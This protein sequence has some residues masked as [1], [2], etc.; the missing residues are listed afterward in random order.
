MKLQE[1]GARET[2]KQQ[3]SIDIK[4]VSIILSQSLIAGVIILLAI[5]IVQ[6]MEI[7]LYFPHFSGQRYDWKIF[8][9]EKQI[10]AVTGEIDSN[11]RVTLNM[12]KAYQ[13]YRGMTRWLL[14]RGG[15]LD[16]IY[17]GKGFSVE[18]L[19]ETPNDQNII[20]TGNPE[21]DFLSARY[22][23]QRIILNKLT[24][25]N[26]LLQVYQSPGT[27]Y[28]PAIEEQRNLYRQFEQVQAERSK[29]SLY[30]ARF[31][32]IVDFTRG[33]ADRT[34]ENPVDHRLYFNNFVTQ[35]LNFEDLYTSGH[36]EQVLHSWL[37][38]NIQSEDGDE[39]LKKRLD[40]VMGR[41]NQDK[42]LGGFAQ[43]AVPFL[44]QKGKDDLLSVISMH[45]NQRPGAMAE[46][47]DAT[48]QMLSSY[49]I[50]TGKNAPDLIFKA[51][52]LTQV[53]KKDTDIIIKLEN[54]DAAYTI[55]LFYK[56]SCALCE[57]ALII[58]ANRY[59]WLKE[60][61]VRVIA[62]SGDDT[63]QGFEKKRIYHQWPDNYCDFAGMD[64]INFRNYA[65]MGTPTLY[66]LDKNGIVLNKS[67][68][69][70]EIIDQIKNDASLKK[71]NTES[72][73]L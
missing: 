64:G 31:G 73:R 30:A 12:P 50:L 70:D 24:A 18:C 41:L 42:I 11:G 67:A 40:A 14:K 4:K 46:L 63:E 61:N 47:S 57:N 23:R 5:S 21:N 60:Q 25:V 65:V 58:L 22:N 71:L 53:G 32:E 34:Y 68:M 52:V 45:L 20:Y 29:S 66:L 3:I 26:Q 10:T 54:L 37:M 27:L 39:A 33:I 72:S 38:M 51:P 36:W 16:M 59:K 49:K 62:I 35:T 48:R 56:G 13:D 19:S 15:G 44:V 2:S 6:A 7:Q 1:N 17:T 69:A 43:T 55:L 8:Q 28:E 9:G